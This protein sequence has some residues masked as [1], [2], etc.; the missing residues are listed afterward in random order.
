MFC[1]SGRSSIIFLLFTLG[2]GQRSGLRTRQQSLGKPVS[3]AR[4]R[5]VGI[6]NFQY[7]A[8]MPTRASCSFGVQHGHQKVIL[9]RDLR[10][11]NILVIETN[12]EPMPRFIDFGLAKATS[13]QLS[14]G[15]MY[16]VGAVIGTLAYMSLEQADSA[17]QDIDTLSDVYSLGEVLYELLVDVPPLDFHVAPA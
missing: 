8:C 10:P 17:G 14:A 16:K 11:S 6:F 5:F 9:H 2:Y 3:A 13:Q 15:T 4:L 12:G 1:C 7:Q